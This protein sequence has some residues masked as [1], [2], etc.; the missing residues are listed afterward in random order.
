L[1]VVLVPTLRAA[2]PMVFGSLETETAAGPVRGWWAKVQLDH[3]AVRVGVTEPPR[4]GAGDPAGT[5][6]KLLP[7]NSWA[8]ANGATLAVNAGFF[9]LVDPKPLPGETKVRYHAGAPA[10]IRGLS[11]SARGL[12]SPPRVMAGRGDPALLVSAGRA[13]VAYAREADLDGVI[14][15]I[16]G[17]GPTDN[18]QEPGTFLVE[19]GRNTGATARVGPKIRHPR[20]AAGVTV[21]GRTLILLA[22]DGRQ[23]GHS[24]GVTLPE[25]AD[26]MLG[27]GAH[28]AV[29]LDGGGSTSFY[30]RRAD[31]SLATNRPSDGAWRPVANHLGVWIDW[32]VS[33]AA[34]STAGEK[35]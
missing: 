17:I 34:S 18:G 3:P 5:E 9:G 23:P 16:A 6:A 25:L 13:R 31:G 7:V 14:G 30:V 4:V 20:T 32:P 11:H 15:A 10:D 27:L 33:P 19:A 12:V 35:K 22:I 28:D 1:L 26:L 24:V 2:E 21:D 29:A 8:E